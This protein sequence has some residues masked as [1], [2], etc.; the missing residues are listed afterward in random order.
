MIN[1][2]LEL[3]RNFFLFF[4]ILTICSSASAVQ[5]AYSKNARTFETQRSS[6]MI[7][8][9]AFS[10]LALVEM[11]D[12][13]PCTGAAVPYATKAHLK[14]NGL[15][16][17]GYA[18]LAKL[19]KIISEEVDAEIVNDL[20][21]EARVLQA[22]AQADVAFI[23]RFLN[24]KYSPFAYRFFS[25]ARN[26]ANPDVEL[27]AVEEQSLQIQTGYKFD[28]LSFGVDFVY[29]EWRFVKEQF[30]L[31]GLLSQQNLEQIKP[32]SFK[33]YFVEPSALYIFESDFKPRISMKG[34]RLGNVS[35]RFDQF[36]FPTELQVGF[37]V[38]ADVLFGKMDFLLDYK[39]IE[40][41]ADTNRKFHFGSLYH[42]GAMSLGF[43]VDDYGVSTG[44]NY[45]LDVIQAG[46]AFST[47]QLPW[48]TDDYYSQTVYLQIGWKL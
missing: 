42:L 15:I 46:V 24:A 6:L 4:L 43:G 16:S 7:K 39:S 19:R 11:P 33:S 18:N 26:V 36:L 21:G 13:L 34:A 32:K 14:V 47:T 23:S 41:T 5:L 9:L 28:Q 30:K 10:C 27:F 37:G 2:T 48:R 12:D 40:S 1:R 31:L 45:G 8:S 22:E 38:T 25:V 20:F 35:E 44:I 17:N 3:N 29:T